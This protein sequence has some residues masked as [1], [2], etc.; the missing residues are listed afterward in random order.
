MKIWL[1]WP[2][3]GADVVYMK[4]ADWVEA[5][6]LTLTCLYAGEDFGGKDRNSHSL[7]FVRRL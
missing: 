6:E 7:V 1:Y 3:E 2:G 5:G 4:T